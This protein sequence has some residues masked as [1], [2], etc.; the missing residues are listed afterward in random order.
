MNYFCHFDVEDPVH[1]KFS[2]SLKV[3]PENP[4]D[5]KLFGSF[6]IGSAKVRLGRSLNFSLSFTNVCEYVPMPCNAF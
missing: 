3:S 1:K 5:W 4:F 6:G 2:K